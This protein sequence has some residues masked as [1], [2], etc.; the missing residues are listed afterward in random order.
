MDR[1]ERLDFLLRRSTGR[2][3]MHAVLAEL[4]AHWGCVLTPG[5]VGPL[6]AGDELRAV[7]QSHGLAF[8]A[9]EVSAE[10][11]LQHAIGALGQRIDP[12]GVFFLP[13]LYQLGAIVA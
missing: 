10:A 13:S 8:R 9:W 11:A 5:D 6:E 3:R 7:V 12:N 4:S 2:M 1:S